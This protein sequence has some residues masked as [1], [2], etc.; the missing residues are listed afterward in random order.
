MLLKNNIKNA[1]LEPDFASTEDWD[2]PHYV[3]DNR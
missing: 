2:I 3:I 1:V